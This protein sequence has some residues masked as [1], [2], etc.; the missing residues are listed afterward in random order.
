MLEFLSILFSSGSIVNGLQIF[1]FRTRICSMNLAAKLELLLLYNCR[2]LQS[3]DKLE[4]A[5]NSKIFSHTLKKFLNVHTN[6][7]SAVHS[8]L[9]ANRIFCENLQ[10]M[11]THLECV[12]SIS[13]RIT[14]LEVINPNSEKKPECLW[15]FN[16]LKQ[17]L[18]VVGPFLR[19]KG[20]IAFLNDPRHPRPRLLPDT[21]TAFFRFNSLQHSFH[22]FSQ[23]IK[24]VLAQAC[25][26]PESLSENQNSSSLPSLTLQSL[27]SITKNYMKNLQGHQVSLALT[28][29]WVIPAILAR[30]ELQRRQL[31]LRNSSLLDKTSKLRS[32]SC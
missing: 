3:Y 24:P 18:E 20:G 19:V 31:P 1:S 9:T 26:G 4:D 25:P 14:S 21:I 29:L 11:V 15:R 16:F 7:E 12:F 28:C 13:P 30:K 5:V 23:K 10:E 2:F 27:S 32:L 8:I 17:V 6:L 22:I